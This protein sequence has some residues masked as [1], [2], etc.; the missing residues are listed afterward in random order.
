MDVR[1]GFSE[2]SGRPPGRRGGPVIATAVCALLAL[3]GCDRERRDLKGPP[4]SAPL[5]VTVSDLYPGGGPTEAP[6]PRAKMYEG[7]AAHIA[8]GQRLYKWFNCAGCHAN[9]GGSIGPALMDSQWRY[10]GSMERIYAS[11]VQGRPNGM[12]AFKDKIPP[13]QV[14]EIAAYVRSLSGNADKLAVPSRPE[15]MTGIPPINNI[16]KQAP[17]EAAR[18]PNDPDFH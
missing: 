13:Q 12:P 11:I 15:T 4:E 6:D 5:S 8:S 7:N 14:W 3:C 17:G 9:G 1:R 2:E 10:G 18:G 16:N